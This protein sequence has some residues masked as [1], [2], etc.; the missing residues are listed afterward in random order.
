MAIMQDT[1]TPS[2]DTSSDP[3]N[4]M[5]KGHG[6]RRPS[7]GDGHVPANMREE[8]FMTRNGLNMKSFQRR[9]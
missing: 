1:K 3:P 5:E 2:P 7:V 4:S 9:E 8:D 6:D